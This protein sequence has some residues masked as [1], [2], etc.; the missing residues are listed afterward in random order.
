MPDS[1]ANLQAAQERAMANRPVAQGFPYLAES[2]RRAGVHRNEWHLPSMQSTYTTDLGPVV[3]QGEP[4]LKG[5]TP[6]PAFDPVALVAALR[7]DQAGETNFAQFAA[8]AWHAG[9]MRYVVDLDNRT[10]TY[11]GM[12]GESFIEAY[13]AVEL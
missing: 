8:A 10:C 9:V 6:V 13:P 3:Q 4:L 5:A 12:G 7:A 1:V 11:Y 2:L